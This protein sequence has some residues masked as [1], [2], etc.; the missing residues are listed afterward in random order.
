MELG[1]EFSNV[2]GFA[3]VVFLGL[4]LR[5]CQKRSLLYL[6]WWYCGPFDWKMDSILFSVSARK[7]RKRDIQKTSKC[8]HEKPPRVVHVS[9][10]YCSSR[11]SWTSFKTSTLKSITVC[12]CLKF[13]VASIYELSDVINCLFHVFTTARLEAV[14][15]LSPEQQSGTHCRM[16]CWLGTFSADLIENNYSLTRGVSAVNFFCM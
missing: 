16:I 11:N 2:C 9:L 8:A 1:I 4:L 7:V 15:L 5:P 14:I 3:L 6:S 10:H 13:P 12:L